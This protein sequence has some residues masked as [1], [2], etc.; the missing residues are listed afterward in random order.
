VDDHGFW[1]MRA[2]ENNDHEGFPACSS[3]QKLFRDRDSMQTTHENLRQNQK[4]YP[5]VRL[6]R[7]FFN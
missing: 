2:F 1:I 7:L 5:S 6:G 4:A 3:L